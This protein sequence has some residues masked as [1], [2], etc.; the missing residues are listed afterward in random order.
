M[1]KTLFLH[2]WMAFALSAIV[3]VTA[4]T[5]KTAQKTEETEQ[6]ETNQTEQ[7]EEP[8]PTPCPMFRDAPDP[9]LAETDYVLYRD[10]IKLGNWAEAFT[11]WRRVYD[12]A[13]AADGKRTTVFTDGVKLYGILVQEASDTAQKKAFI[14]TIMM[15]YDKMDECFHDGGRVTGLK[16]FNLY[17]KYPYYKPKKEVYEL[18]KKSID[19]DEGKGRYFILNPFTAL[20]VELYQ[21]GEISMEE[22]QS[23]EQKIRESIAHGLANCQDDCDHWKMVEQYAPERLKDFETVKGFYD[24]AY[25]KEQYLDEFR[26]DPENCDIIRTVYSRLKWGGCPNDDPEVKEVLIAGNTKCVEEQALQQA[27]NELRNGNYKKALELF[28]QAADDESD[29]E[30]KAGIYYIMAKVYY[31]HLRNFPRARQYARMALKY[32]P[33]WGD[34][35]ILI[36]QLYA[37]SGPLCGPGR[38][39][40]SQV[41]VWAAIDKWKRAKAVDPSVAAK[42]NKLINRYAQYM[43]SKGEI[44]QRGLQEGSTYTVPCWIQEKTII[45]PAPSN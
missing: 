11:Y 24:C 20:L 41:V 29:P 5:P 6:E 12:E 37:S 16:A 33:N 9:D 39:W 35:Y 1:K 44:F 45:R 34:P 43:P 7:A 4:C 8:R 32:K 42:A 30:K 13:P 36:G 14:D 23:Y 22:A 21:A 19:M 31:A 27:Y 26:E 18:F 38:G 17:Y 25:Y 10:Q 15:I 40:D 3:Y 2:V 28:Q